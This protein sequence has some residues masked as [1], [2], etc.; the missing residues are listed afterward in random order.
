MDI[1]VQANALKLI[2]QLLD[3]R[4]STQPIIPY[5]PQK[6][7]FPNHAQRQPFPSATP[8]SQGIPSAYLARFIEELQADTSLDL[9]TLMILKNGFVI[10]ET[11]FGAYDLHTWTQVHSFS[12]SITGLAIGMLIDDGLLQPDDHLVDL[13]AKHNNI[14]SR[15]TQKN[16]TLAHLLTM[17]SGVVFNEIGALTETD[18]LKAFLESGVRFE[19][20]SAFA[21]NSMNSYLLSALVRE[22]SGQGLM[23]FLQPRLFQPLAIE[24]VYWE[25]CPKGI[26]KGGWGL[27]L[28][29]EDMAKIGQLYLQQGNWQGQQLVSKQWIQEAIS[30]KINVPA[31]IGEYNYGYQT[32]VSRQEHAFLLNGMFGQN[33]IGFPES[34]ILIVTTGGVGELFQSSGFF[35]L[36]HRY[37]KPAYHPGHFLPEN[38]E[39]YLRLQRLRHLPGHGWNKT[40]TGAA[41]PLFH[42]RE[43][44]LPQ[45]C[46][47]LDRRVY[48]FTSAE[49][50]SVGLFP[51]IAQIMQNN[52]TK[53]I[54]R[55]KFQIS[56]H[57]FLLIVQEEDESYTLPIGFQTDRFTA[58]SLHG[59][60]YLIGCRGQF[61]LDEDEHLVLKLRCSFLELSVARL[62]KFYFD[63]N[64]L[65]VN[66]SESPG[67]EVIF[68]ALSS[69]VEEASKKKLLEAVIARV[70]A[71]YLVYRIERSF[72]PVL[73]AK[74]VE[75]ST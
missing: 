35:R 16:I 18:W 61:A 56:D 49:A 29:P 64:Q 7:V 52:Y 69:L 54:R 59:E 34:Q 14:L 41:L 2:G 55:L 19:A 72:N 6:A 9:H 32:W 38:T 22:I 11:S 13:F 66:F 4:S 71:D 68:E 51:L 63:G 28:A 39:A 50:D 73:T 37:F 44:G 53:G 46:L 30:T 36:L 60:S 23:E 40:E 33:V 17:S 21:Y 74:V 3:R 70:D 62:I 24:N 67:K 57:L 42:S 43:P 26:E 25:V 48:A 45:A 20:G 8:E 12:K 58:L 31:T 15:L 5:L 75:E 47:T 1:T 10:A 27:Y 65:R